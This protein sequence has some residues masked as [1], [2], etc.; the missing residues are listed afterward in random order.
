[1]LY[2]QHYHMVGV[3][4]A[5]ISNFAEFRIKQERTD[6]GFGCQR[7]LNEII[8]EFDKLLDKQHFQAIEKI[9]TVGA[10]YMCVVGLIPEYQIGMNIHASEV[11]YMTVL[12]EFFFAMLGRLQD[13]NR[14][15]EN[16]FKMHGGMNSG[17]VVAGVIGSRKPH[18]DIWGNTVNVASRMET[19]SKPNCCLV[20][21]EVHELLRDN[22][23]FEGPVRKTIKGKGT[24]ETYFMLG[25]KG[26]KGG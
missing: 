8:A 4:F 3:L 5:K 16:S 25:S 21:A 19:N 26:K 11:K 10:S 15:S 22:F 12:A 17:P 23:E 6:H 2:Y 1:E 20:T 14:R 13:I 9:K 24:M 18:Y 7:L